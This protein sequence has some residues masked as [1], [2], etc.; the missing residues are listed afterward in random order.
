MITLRKTPVTTTQLLNFHS[1]N[2]GLIPNGVHAISVVTWGCTLLHVRYL[3]QPVII[4][5]LMTKNDIIFT[6]HVL[7]LL[8]KQ[9]PRHTPQM[10]HSL[11]AYCATLGPPSIFRCSCFCHQVP[12]HGYTTQETS[13]SERRNS[14]GEN[15]PVILPKCRLPRYI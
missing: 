2:T 5:R 3:L 1:Q 11:D 15:C 7:L 6:L 10:H 4:V 14:M 13:S 9:G 12:S 8:R